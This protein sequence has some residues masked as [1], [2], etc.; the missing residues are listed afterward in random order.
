MSPRDQ[1]GMTLIELLVAMAIMSVIT[2]MTLLGW[3]ALSDSYS[4]SVK[5][6]D[7]R[8]SGR[9][10]IARVQREVR[11][12]QRPAIGY[13]SG[14]A[15]DAAVYRARSYWIALCTTFNQAGN[16]EADWESNGSSYQA[17]STVPRLVVYRLYSNN[18]LYRFEDLNGNWKIDMSNGGTFDMSPSTDNPS[19]F[20][21][22]EIKYGEGAR[23][24]LSNVV[25]FTAHPS[26]P[27]PVFTYNHYDS[28]GVLQ[29]DHEA[30]NADR[31]DII[32]VGIELL[33][34]LNPKHAPVY[35]DLFSTAQLRNQR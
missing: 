12:A 5:S 33:V 27:S 7:A 16:S 3:F 11:D 28:S 14:T 1:A 23:L 13:L 2:A 32:A 10:A 8:D 30:F 20:N 25:N 19:G 6:A 24:I 18:K 31:Y 21:L 9:Q 15:A 22:N 26:T 34:D 4:Y 35:A 29:S 17:V